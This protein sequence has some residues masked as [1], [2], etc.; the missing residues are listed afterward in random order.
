MTEGKNRIMIYGPKESAPPATPG[1]SAPL[2]P[3]APSDATYRISSKIGAFIGTRF[4]SAA[5]RTIIPA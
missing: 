1:G 2:Q 3:L 5:G 4:M